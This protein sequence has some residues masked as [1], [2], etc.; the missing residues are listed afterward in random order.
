MSQGLARHFSTQRVLSK[1]TSHVRVVM[2]NER[3]QKEELK[4][5]TV[6]QGFFSAIKQHAGV[7]LWLFSLP[8]NLATPQAETKFVNAEGNRNQAWHCQANAHNHKPLGRGG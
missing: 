7:R 8:S 3:L 2:A 4:T 1:L 6:N 5:P